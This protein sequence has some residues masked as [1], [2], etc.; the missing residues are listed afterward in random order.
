M[1]KEEDEW[2]KLFLREH[3][4]FIALQFVQ[5]VIMLTILWFAQM[6]DLN[7]LLYVVFVHFFLAFIYML[8]Y[9]VTRRRLYL[10]KVEQ[11]EKSEEVMS[12]LGYYP[13]PEHIQEMLRIQYKKYE[14]EVTLLQSKQE[15]YMTYVDLWAHQMKTPL[16]VIELMAQEADEPLSS[17]LREEVGRLKEGLDMMLHMARLRTIEH[18]FSVKN[19]DVKKMIRQIIKEE[20][21]LFIRNKMMPEL[22]LA[23]DVRIVYSDEKWLYFI[24]E[25]L[26]HNAV[27]YSSGHGKYIKLSTFKRQK[28]TVIA[29]NDEGVGIPKQDQ[30]RV[31][32]PFFTGEN[33]RKFRRESTG[34][35]LYIVK[36]ICTF[37]NHEIRIISDGS[38]GTTVE[39]IFK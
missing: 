15:Q 25:Q 37:L 10:K 18:D 3:R 2:M 36:E 20:R 4:S 38:N 24:L 27:K 5:S 31:F 19:I 30:K 34:V 22:D 32:E 11:L 39:I 26:I 9:L 8:Y 16:S 23:E 7:I 13:L 33:G 17:E 35:G 1:N 29:I 12:F 28:T 21:R 6:R 14:T